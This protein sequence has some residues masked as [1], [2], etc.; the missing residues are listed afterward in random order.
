VPAVERA[1]PAATAPRNV[2]ALLK[3]IR[4]EIERAAGTGHDWRSVIDSLRPDTRGLWRQ[5]PLAEKQRFLR[6]V[7]PWWDVHRHRMAPAVAA[8]IE[9][10]RASGQLT[11]RRARLGRIICRGRL[12][13]AELLPIR[14]AAP[15]FVQAARVVGCAGPLGNIEQIPSPLVR[16]LLNEGVLRADPLGIGLDVTSEGAAIDREGKVSNWLFAIGPITRGVFWESTAVP[17][18]RLHAEAL[19]ADLLPAPVAADV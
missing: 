10:A 9:A 12:V 15:V 3:R 14:A 19:A 4:R 13:E 7:R 1:L 6:H 17:D 2:L 16:Q 18:L 8:R 11:V 5:L